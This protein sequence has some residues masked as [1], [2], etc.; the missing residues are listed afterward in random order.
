VIELSR[1]VFQPLRKDEEFILYR[2][3]SQDDPGQVLV[4]SPAVERPRPE[5]LRR[6]EHEYSLRGELDPA[7][8]ARSIEFTH[9]RD[10]TALVMED[11]GGMPLDRLLV[12]PLELRLW[13][14][15]AIG[16]S[17]ALNHLHQRGII[18]KDIKPANVLADS[19][20]GQCWL[21]GFLISSRLPR[22]RQLPQS[23]EFIAGT[24]AYLAPEQTGRMNRSVDSRSDLYALGVTLYQM[25]TGNLPFTAVDPMEWVHC[26]IA[27]QPVPPDERRNDVPPVVSAII[28]KLLSKAPEQRYQT[29]AG[30]EADLR[31][32]LVEWESQRSVSW[33]SLGSHDISDRFLI[34]EKLY[35]RERE[36]KVLV[37]AFDQVVATGRPN[38]VLVSGHSGIGKSSVVNELHKVLVLPRGWPVRNESA[39]ADVGGLFASGKFD[40]YKRDI[41]YATLAQAF[42]SLVSPL[43]SES[44]AE[45]RSWREALRTALGPNGQLMVDLIP[46]LKLIIGEQPAVPHLPPK[47]ARRRFQLVFLRFVGVFARPEH[48]LA[49]FLDDLQ[50]LDAATLDFLEHLLTEPDVHHLMLIGAYRDNEVGAAHLLRRRLEAIR[51]TGAIVHDI[52]LAPLTRED[53][54]GMIVDCLHCERERAVPLAH[55][56]HDKTAGNPF[57]TV[58]FISTL[59][60]E[61]LLTFDHAAARWSWDL[62]GIQAKR[63]TD[64]VVDLMVEKLSRLPAETREGLQGLACLGNIAE[65]TML[66]AVLGTP[67]EELHVNLWEAVRAGL[68]FR[69][70]GAYEFLHDRIQ[71]AAYSLIP[72]E[73]RAEVH[74]RI[75]RVLVASMT[76]DQL[77]E[78]LFDVV[79]QFDLSATQLL[80][81]E[82]KARMA[83]VY[84]R[85]GRK[86]KAAAAFESARRYFE[87][88]M[89]LLDES[90]WMSQYEVMFGLRLEGAE[91]ELLTGNLQKAEQLIEELLQRSASKVDQTGAYHLKVLLHTLKSENAQAVETALTSLRLLGIEIAAHPNEEQVHAEYEAVWRSLDGRP[92]ES[93]IELPPMSDRALQSAMQVLSTALGAVYFTDM[94]LFNLL[95]CRMANLTWQHGVCGASAHGFAY[96]GGIL[97]PVFHRY[98][99]GNR[100]ARLACDLVDKHGFIAYQAKVYHAMALVAVW[101]QPLAT[102]IDFNQAGF[103]AA[104]ETGDLTS[105]CYSMSRSV[106]ILLL[107]GDPLDTVWQESERSLEFASKAGY[108]DTADRILCQQRFIAAMQGRTASLSSLSDAQFDESTFETQLTNRTALMVCFYW[109]IKLQSRFLAGEYR[110]ALVAA[111]KAKELLWSAVAHI[112]MLDYFYYTA[113]TVTSL[114]ESAAPGMQAE[115][116]NLLAAHREQL[117]E[118]ADNY[119]PTFA[120]KYALVSAEI[121]RIEGRDLEAMRLYDDAIRAARENGFVQNEGIAYELATRFYTA[122]GFDLIAEAYLRRARYCYLRWGGAGKVRQLD[123]LYPQLR[124][125]EPAPGPTTTIGAPIESLDLATVIKLSQAVSGEMVFEKLIE[126]LMHTAVEHAGAERGV[127]I[128]D[129]GSE[130]RIQAEATIGEGAIRVDWKRALAEVTTVP[131]SILRYVARTHES[132]ILNDASSQPPFSEDSY[133]RRRGARSVLCLPLINQSK[134]IGILYLENNLASQVFTPARIAV[135]KL[136]ASQAAISLENTRLYRDLAQREA[137]IRRLVDANIVG[138]FIGNLDGDIVEANEAFLR[139]LGY[140]REDL[141]SGRLRWTDLTPEELRERDQRAAAE[142]KTTGT[143]QPYQKEFFRKD[144]KRVPVMLGAATFEGSANEGVAFVLDLSG[145]KRA[146]EALQKAQADLAHMTRVLT[147]GEL[148]ASIAHEI[149]QPLAAIVTNGD[150][151]LRWLSGD[152][153]NLDETSK[154]IRRIIRDGKRATAVVSRMRALFKKTPTEKEPLDLNDVVQEVV[155]ITQSEAQRNGISLR[156]DFAED[157]PQV[158]G[159]KV[160]LQQVILNLLVNAIQALSGLS[161]GPRELCVSSRKVSQNIEGSAPVEHAS[162]SS[163]E[164]LAKGDARPTSEGSPPEE[165]LIEVRDSGPGLDPEHL[166][167][168]FEAFY[169]TKPQGLGIGLT[170]SRTIAEAHGGRLWAEPN[171]P[172]GA[173]FQFALPVW[174]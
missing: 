79:N 63:Y 146:E 128:L 140:T 119:P 153:P 131:Q 107:R 134:L 34:P 91:C 62:D 103:R 167:R 22:E 169:T 81:P 113:L 129:Q 44:E 135:L 94:Q 112:Q 15:L 49:L 42:Q 8:A 53:L 10:R 110:E 141:V 121:A 7:W 40:Q 151:G 56:V 96:L 117:R 111:E 139:M 41:P 73:R 132:V 170:I 160:Q 98:E 145:Q 11:P 46:E 108:R 31:K 90:A 156:T 58:Q 54:S 114:Y 122:R 48:P 14:R 38:L 144:G 67:E 158:M 68:V 130:P 2:G 66:S 115:W 9:H 171:E 52:I 51:L 124:E 26:H 82:E 18:H 133:I 5:S 84:L 173:V 99:A 72:E 64:N 71:Q 43:L 85:S 50:W 138:I 55:L 29:A 23:P 89:G 39:A 74:L 70:S 16:L 154:A 61:R 88:G 165:I 149:N 104:M 120:D 137:K 92:I 75:S 105:A 174:S 93:L 126:T 163:S 164:A 101:T 87:T 65:T 3:R 95:A 86:A 80:E 155:A 159:D 17:S 69:E 4:L 150:A 36:I 25:L 143:L 100:F 168:L 172:R 6:L 32:C 161:E 47:E 24:L 45:L 152:T 27:R 77:E 123:E 76:A 142:L 21:H 102:V 83:T 148:T 33:F 118:W 166:N 157:L 127:L 59:V 116:R 162:L 1:Y 19:V 125:L 109:I 57:F 13:L 30:L 136:L 12:E 35:G 106:T 20:T 78:N 37:D 147:V 60:E 97:G 28:L